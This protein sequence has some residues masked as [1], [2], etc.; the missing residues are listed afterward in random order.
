MAPLMDLDIEQYTSKL[1]CPMRL[2]LAGV[3]GLYTCLLY[4]IIQ[5]KGRLTLLFISFLAKVTGLYTC[6]LYIIIRLKGRLTQPLISS[7]IR[8]NILD[9]K[10]DKKFQF[11]AKS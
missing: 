5:L 2:V 11:Y 9:D 6:L 3:T 10:T 4:I 8:K 7:R 1:E